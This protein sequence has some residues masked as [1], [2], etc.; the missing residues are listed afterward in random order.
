MR[1]RLIEAL[2]AR[3]P[4]S[5]GWVILA[6]VC[7]AGFSRQGAAV[8]TLSIFVEPMTQAFGW[9]RTELSGA[10]SIGGIL[11]AL[12][13]PA[14]GSFLDRNGARAVLGLAVLLTA[15]STFMLSFTHSLAFFYLFYCTAR[16]SFAGPYDLG[17]YGSIVSWFV[18]R[19]TFATSI[20][21]LAQMCGLVAMPLIAHFVIDAAGWRGA[22]VAIG[23][24]VLVVGF[25]PT[26]LLHLRRP[27]D[28]GQRPDG[29]A[30]PA[31]AA[32]AGGAAAPHAPAP[33]YSRREALR[34]PAFWL[35]AL[36]TL[37]VYPVQS[38]ISLHQAPLLIERGLDP[39]VAAAA[40]STFAAM[41]AVAGFGYGFWPRAVPLRFALA[42]VAASLLA[43]SLLMNQRARRA[44]RLRRGGAVRPRHRR[45]ADRAAGGLGRV[46][47]APR[48]TARSAGVALTIQVAAQAAGPVLSGA[49]R[50]ATGSYAASLWTFSALALAGTLAALFSKH[51]E[52]G[53]ARI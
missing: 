42:L 38:G 37:L 35:L 7:A 46:L 51:P 29:D 4:F 30:A 34:T 48:A 52:A 6:C 27:E 23:A 41:S 47:R 50:D 11:G 33:A 36:Y 17:I 15:V 19:R 24:T 13:A 31:R 43:S 44:R 2:A 5:Y 22:W 21:T 39:A 12:V 28:L 3:L 14:L 25:L 9:S 1:R 10:V 45:P 8:A 26:W 49:L 16:M 20:A 18:R 40:V 32:A 53:S